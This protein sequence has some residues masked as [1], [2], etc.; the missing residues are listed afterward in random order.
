[1]INYG[2][3]K[4]KS[5]IHIAIL[6]QTWTRS[7]L[8]TVLNTYTESIVEDLNPKVLKLGG[9]MLKKLYRRCGF[10]PDRRPAEL[11]HNYCSSGIIMCISVPFPVP[12]DSA[13]ILP[14]WRSTIPLHI[15]RPRPTPPCCRV[16]EASTW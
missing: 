5:S 16:D 11:F 8:R 13:Q 14:P 4:C 1:M 2:W 15:E 6:G 7:V 3:Q 10:L 12:S 9:S